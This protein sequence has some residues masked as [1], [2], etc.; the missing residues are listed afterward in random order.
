[1]DEIMESGLGHYLQDIQT[2]CAEIHDTIYSTYIAYP[3][4]DRLH[5]D[6]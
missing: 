2:R 4:A 5:R 1:V 3:I 6:Q